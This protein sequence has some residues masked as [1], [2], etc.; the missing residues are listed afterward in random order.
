[1]KEE[2]DAIDLRDLDS[3]VGSY[4]RLTGSVVGFSSD[5]LPKHDEV[6]EKMLDAI[7]KLLK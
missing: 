4:A 6:R 5:V 1:M 2:L 7:I 3:L